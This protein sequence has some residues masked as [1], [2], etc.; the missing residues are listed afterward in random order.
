[1]AAPPGDTPVPKRPMLLSPAEIRESLLAWRPSWGPTLPEAVPLPETSSIQERLLSYWLSRKE[2]KFWDV[3]LVFDDGK[4]L[5]CSKR[6]LC[7]MSQYFGKMFEGDFAEST[8]KKVPIKDVRSYVMVKMVESY[9]TGKVSIPLHARLWQLGEG[10]R[11][12]LPL[13]SSSL[14]LRTHWPENNSPFL[15]CDGIM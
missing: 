8:E 3:Y 2:D 13:K 15:R 6:D 4:E 5:L 9:Y 1:M 11:V 12:T 10:E 14:L 7:L